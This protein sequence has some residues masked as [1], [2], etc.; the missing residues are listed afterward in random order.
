[1]VGAITAAG[2]GVIFLVVAELDR[3]VALWP[4]GLAIAAV[5]GVAFHLSI[6]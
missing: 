6:P 1:M 2:L 4:L 5:L 3:R